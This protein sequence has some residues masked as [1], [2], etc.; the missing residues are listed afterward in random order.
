MRGSNER[1]EHIRAH[2]LPW[3]ENPEN[4]RW[5]NMLSPAIEAS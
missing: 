1:Q 2:F 5:E 4:V 3:P